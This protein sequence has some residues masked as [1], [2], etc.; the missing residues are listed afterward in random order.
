[1]WLYGSGFPKSHDIGKAIDKRGGQSIGWFGPWLRTERER[2]GISQR[3][4]AERGG[5]YDKV[6]HGGAVTNC[7]VGYNLPTVEQ[8]NL[9][10]EL[11]DLPFERMEEAEREVIG[12]SANG[13]AGGTKQLAGVD[14]AWGFNGEFN[15]T[16][17]ATDAA[18]Q[19][20][21]W[22]TNLKPSFEP[23]IM[24]RKPL[25]GTVDQNVLLQ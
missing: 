6:N 9:I 1:M 5:F 17:P 14:G 10:C 8:F 7:E 16:A 21:G 22:G 3:E 20:D 4:L 18:R 23:I 25:I 19:W 15:I 12:R 11:L 24:A 13:I 2:R